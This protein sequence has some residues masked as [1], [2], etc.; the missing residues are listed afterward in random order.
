MFNVVDVVVVVV[1]VASISLLLLLV[2]KIVSEDVDVVV[3][4]SLP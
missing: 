4:N 3:R 2:G 1:V